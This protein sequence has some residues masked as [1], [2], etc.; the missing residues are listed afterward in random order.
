MKIL[1]SISSTEFNVEHFPGYLSS[2]EVS[3]PIFYLP[4][5]K[6][7]S[8]MNKW[9][10]QELTKT[11]AYLLFLALLNSTELVHFR[12][13]I[14]KDNRTDSIIAQ[15]MERLALTVTKLNTVYTPSVSFP[16]FATS[17]DNRHLHNV[18]HWIDDWCEAYEEF[19]SGKRRDADNRKLAIR[20]KALERLIKNPH[21]TVSGYARNLADWAAD[22][23]S[24][25]VFNTKNPYSSNPLAMISCADYWKSIIIKA[26]SQESIY[27]IDRKDIIEILEH[28][29]ENIPIGSIYSNALFTVLRGALE[30]Q[31]NYLGLGD[32]DISSGKYQF[33]N[34]G[35]SLEHANMRALIDS[36]PENEPIPSE[37]PTKLSYLKAKMRWEM[38]RNEV[39][40]LPDGIEL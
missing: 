37:Y 38:A 31:K 11:D 13:P 39:S 33:L 18:H 6:L 35:D 34:S 23:G 29:E 20:E 15:N 32:I 12:V 22:A 3:H 16:N 5:K 30:K 28:C 19:K 21:K 9:S 1:C 26:A 14:F 25:P 10:G 24:F 27:A 17:P 8:Y 40:Q 36:A 4:Q 7:L 2:R